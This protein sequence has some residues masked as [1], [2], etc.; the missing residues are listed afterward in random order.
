MKQAIG[1]YHHEYSVLQSTGPV[2]GFKIS[3]TMRVI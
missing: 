1:T 3:G 2:N